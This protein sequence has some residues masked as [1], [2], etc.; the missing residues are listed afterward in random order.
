MHV[1]DLKNELFLHKFT[2]HTDQISCIVTVDD[3]CRYVTTS[4][5]RCVGVQMQQCKNVTVIST[6]NVYHNCSAMFHIPIVTLCTRSVC[7]WEAIGRGGSSSTSLLSR[8]TPASKSS[9]A[10][11]EQREISEYEVANPMF[12]PQC[13]DMIE[14]AGDS[15]NR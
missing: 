3:T 8:S 6:T 9:A 5:D 13:L 11:P 14:L 10:A 4:W 12:R 1:V 2:G 15:K 7:V